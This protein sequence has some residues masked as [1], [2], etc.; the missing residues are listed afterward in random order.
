MGIGSGRQGSRSSGMMTTHK[1]GNKTSNDATGWPPTLSFISLSW[2][3]HQLLLFVCRVTA[4]SVRYIGRCRGLS[5]VGHNCAR[6][7]FVTLEE[8]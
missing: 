7:W 8:E 6:V 1:A 5:D 3:V 4:G 2:F